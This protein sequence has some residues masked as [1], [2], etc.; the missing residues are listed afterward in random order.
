MNNESF[1]EEM[2]YEYPELTTESVVLDCGG[3]EGRF[4][5]EI[6]RRHG[7]HVHVLEPV[8]A[9]YERT[10]ERVKEWPKVKVWP[11]G[12]GG[13]TKDELFRIKGD[14]T[15]V[16]ADGGGDLEWVQLWGINHL[17]RILEAREIDLLKLNVEG[18]E[19]PV[20]TSLTDL[21]MPEWF[22]NIQVQWHGVAPRAGERRESIMQELGKTHALTWDF[23]WT[24][25]NWRVRQ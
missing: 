2:R 13:Q 9:F 4:A 15:G 6:S 1:R 8:R 25:Q 12:I 22:K 24:W 21:G 20:L 18:A 5:E 10:R 19:F 14:M 16:Y 23:G 11:F 7:C 3:Y 17:W